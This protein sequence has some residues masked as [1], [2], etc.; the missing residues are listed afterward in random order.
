MNPLP[1][2]E[3]KKLI[4]NTY[5]FDVPATP[6]VEHVVLKQTLI[7]SIHEFSEINVTQPYQLTAYAKN[8]EDIESMISVLT[9]IKDNFFAP[10]ITSN[11]KETEDNVLDSMLQKLY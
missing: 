6:V 10:L 4:Q 8:L 2:P 3:P 11:K 5:E 1:P 7:N 9:Y